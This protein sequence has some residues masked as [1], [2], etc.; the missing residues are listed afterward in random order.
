MKN[1]LLI[2]GI[3]LL[4]LGVVALV[5]PE[6]LKEPIGF[7]KAIKALNLNELKDGLRNY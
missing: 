6:I 5:G 3:T 1:L 2:L 4:F 7:F